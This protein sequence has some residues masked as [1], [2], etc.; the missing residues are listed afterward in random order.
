MKN[1]F[2]F[3][4]LLIHGFTQSQ[5]YLYVSEPDL[6]KIKAAIAVDNS[7]H[8]L[9]YQS[10]KDRVDAGSLEVYLGE[11]NH[12]NRSY[13]AQ[14]AAL[15][16]L[17]SCNIEQQKKYAQLAYKTIKD[18]YENTEQERLPQ[19]GY[20]LSRAMMQLGIALPYTWCRQHWNEKERQYLSKKISEALD[21][22]LT[23]DHA[24]F[25]SERGSNWVAVCRGG[26]LILM[27]A[28]KQEQKRKERY[29]YLVEQL[30]LHMQNGY[31]SLGVSQEGMG[32]IEYGVSFLLKAV[33]AA[34]S[35]GDST[36]LNEAKKHEWW[37]LAMYTESFQ[38]FER[39][40]LM[41]GV[42]GSSAYNEG[43]ASLLLNLVPPL[44]KP[45][46]SWWYDIHMG[47]KAPYAA[48]DKFDN[49][50]AGTIWSILYYP[51]SNLSMDPTNV[52]PPAVNDD[53]GY[54]FFRNRWQD[55]NDLLLSL[56][57]DS[58]HHGNAWDQPEVF[59]INFMGY[60]N[61]FF[62]GPGK[63]REDKYYSTLLVN[64]KY[65]IDKSVTLM[66][67]TE[68][69]QPNI[70]GGKLIVNG[71]NLYEQLGADFAQR[72]LVVKFLENNELVM[73]L[74]DTIRA[75][76][77]NNYT[78]QANLGSNEG[79]DS[80]QISSNHID[81]QQVAINIYGRANA[82][83]FGWF[84][85][86]NIE[87]TNIGD[88]LQLQ[89]E[90]KNAAILSVFWLTDQPELPNIH[91]TKEK[92]LISFQIRNQTIIYNKKLNDIKIE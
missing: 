2:L 79:K 55:E 64:D 27:L 14:E 82:N 4:F 22:W 67:K 36:L 83:L 70:D 76:K 34:A 13:L 50:R 68:Y 69:W 40:F 86:N 15:V 56:M 37:R 38:S 47:V 81:K 53:H 71:G 66:G 42:A 61:R 80:L 65:N 11:P 90:G 16:S 18:I 54:Y 77:N 21:A 39:K 7:H 57:A 89:V 30:L 23:Y 59:C 29:G 91:F 45:Y 43:F 32:Y 84:T 24:N 19:E 5:P 49:H 92:D 1:A 87:T 20:G 88:P 73:V 72:H 17:M 28:A 75:S 60:N 6:E 46:Y 26:E 52:F 58:H 44:Y 25:G 48:A 62:G 35:A 63:K 74:L 51:E 8:Y 78:W 31:G 41:T 12:Y 9:A 33:F 85:S 10:L 3:I